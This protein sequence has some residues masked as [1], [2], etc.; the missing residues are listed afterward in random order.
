MRDRIGAIYCD[1][2]DPKKYLT[3][4]ERF[5]SRPEQPAGGAILVAPPR[6]FKMGEEWTLKQVRSCDADGYLV[7]NYDHLD[8]F[9]DQRRVG[10]FS[11]NIANHLS[12]E[13]FKQH[14]GLERITASYDLNFAQ[15]EALLAAAPPDWFE[16][17]IHQHMP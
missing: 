4:V 17:T 12:A 15:L 1:F 2:D 6:I 5:R 10:D 11:L 9:A 7:R 16:V 3:A 13:Y 8:Y 14:F